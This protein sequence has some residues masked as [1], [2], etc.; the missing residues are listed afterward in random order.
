MCNERRGN[1][2]TVVEVARAGGD[3]GAVPTQPKNSSSSLVKPRQTSN[4]DVVSESALRHSSD[5]P[6]LAE[7]PRER[8]GDA[9]GAGP[10]GSVRGLR[11]GGP[12]RHALATFVDG[13]S[14]RPVTRAVL[15]HTSTVRP[16]MPTSTSIPRPWP[17][18]WLATRRTCWARVPPPNQRAPRSARLWWREPRSSVRFEDRR[19]GTGRETCAL[20]PASVTGTRPRVGSRIPLSDWGALVEDR[21]RSRDRPL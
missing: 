6:A 1:S 2:L 8:G 10:G 21:C 13:R 15:G 11:H 9:G 14:G 4:A 20:A 16:P 18:G 3:P 12:Y 7:P 5:A 19:R 17:E